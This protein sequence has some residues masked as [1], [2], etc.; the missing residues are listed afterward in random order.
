MRIV[1]GGLFAADFE[2]ETESDPKAIKDMLR[3]RV[4]ALVQSQRSVLT[5]C[6]TSP[7]LHHNLHFRSGLVLGLWLVCSTRDSTWNK[8]AVLS[9]EGRQMQ[10]CHTGSPALLP[11]AANPSNANRLSM[12][13]VQPMAKRSP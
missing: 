5:S 13:M 4:P 8:V 9:A 11:S 2:W 12:G 10:G 6:A 3:E 7:A 1:N